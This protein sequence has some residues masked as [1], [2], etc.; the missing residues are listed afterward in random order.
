MVGILLV[1]KQQMTE[2]LMEFRG[3]QIT[4]PYSKIDRTKGQKKIF[5]DLS[6]LNIIERV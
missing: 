3:S 4:D 2:I 6:N 1:K 5:N